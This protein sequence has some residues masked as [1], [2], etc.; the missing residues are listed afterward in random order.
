MNDIFLS[1]R[2]NNFIDNKINKNNINSQKFSQ[3]YYKS[4]NPKESSD[5]VLQKMQ[6][7][8]NNFL[9]N[10]KKNENIESYLSRKEDQASDRDKSLNF[11]SNT[12][13]HNY[14]NFQSMNSLNEGFFRGKEKSETNLIQKK[15]NRNDDSNIFRSPFEQEKSQKG[16][17]LFSNSM[18]S[19]NTFHNN[20]PNNISNNFIN[21]NNIKN[22]DNFHSN[23]I[24]N[25]YK[26]NHRGNQRSNTEVS[27]IF[28]QSNNEILISENSSYSS[29]DNN[30]S[31]NNNYKNNKINNNNN[32]KN[33]KN[34]EVMNNIDYDYKKIVQKIKDKKANEQKE[35][36]KKKSD[37]NI[38]NNISNP[39]DSSGVKFKLSNEEIISNSNNKE[40]NKFRNI[41]R[42]NRLKEN[43]ISF[44][45]A[46]TENN[47]LYSNSTILSKDRNILDSNLMGMEFIKDNDNDNDNNNNNNNNSNKNNNDISSHKTNYR[48]VKKLI[49]DQI[50]P[51]EENIIDKKYTT[52]SNINSEIANNNIHSKG[53]SSS[54]YK[55][56][57]NK[58]YKKDNKSEIKKENSKIKN[59]KNIKTDL[60][61]VIPDNINNLAISGIKNERPKEAWMKTYTSSY[62][63][64]I[65]NNKDKNNE[66]KRISK[67]KNKDRNNNI[68]SKN[69]KN[70]KNNN[71]DE[72]EE[73]NK[74]LDKL[75][76]ENNM[77]KEKIANKGSERHLL[78]S[79]PKNN[80]DWDTHKLQ[81]RI[82]ELESKLSDSKN[83][84]SQINILKSQ[85]TNLYKDYYKYK[86]LAESLKSENEK[87]LKEKDE[88]KKQRDILNNE[89]QILKININPGHHKNN[90]TKA[91]S[92]QR[93]LTSQSEKSGD[94][95]GKGK[96]KNNNTIN[97]PFYNDK[98]NLLD[99]NDF[100]NQSNNKFNVTIIVKNDNFSILRDSNIDDTDIK[101][102]S[103]LKEMEKI[104]NEKNQIIS[105]Y[106]EKM[107]CLEKEKKEEIKKNE[108]LKKKKSNNNF[109]AEDK[110]N[111][112]KINNSKYLDEINELRNNI[113]KL[114]NEK[115]LLKNKIDI[116]ENKKNN[117]NMQKQIADLKKQI[118]YS[119][120]QVKT[121]KTKANE[122]D[123]LFLMIKSFIKMIKPSND[124]E[125][126]LYYKLKNY[127]DHLDKEKIS[128]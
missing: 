10:L 98:D 123:E 28:P 63:N 53:E 124:K 126:D 101:D 70:I 40:E 94:D 23:T 8:L 112:E 25:N 71:K 9:T 105:N 50:V 59:I 67:S 21:S 113:K 109:K 16:F 12:L 1:Q 85:R 22:N 82:K 122:F 75:I 119:N 61:D 3:T 92:R 68:S 32:L 11:N 76:F 37:L 7:S 27:N 5:L 88:Y 114:E 13:S 64:N 107:Q 55:I 100:F 17:S 116:I 106:K 26:Y 127:I 66:N 87:L 91:Y 52:I 44:P 35:N 120:N 118:N 84:K 15:I 73:K 110:N 99:P 95:K 30:K 42:I 86:Q 60:A 72:N 14:S 49:E 125:K 121:F 56:I 58:K 36:E 97:L 51:I 81:Q 54:M 104:I 65:L 31:Q 77:L 96:Y 2:Y 4:K 29:D 93:L 78:N 38:F 6:L 111:P 57:K 45:N 74:I 48:S 41:S 103:K 18:Y 39:S 20:G 19:F 62:Y 34:D 83:I 33:V 47:K 69:I 115:T 46:Y 43:I 102:T 128:K 80:K 24:D 89:V 117:N 108:K 90:I 79:E